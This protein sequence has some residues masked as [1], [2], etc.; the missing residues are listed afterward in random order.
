MSRIDQIV[1]KYETQLSCC[2]CAARLAADANVQRT[3][4]A[5]AKIKSASPEWLAAHDRDAIQALFAA[6]E[7]L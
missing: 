5:I 1:A 3:V 2:L 4:A 7:A 6:A